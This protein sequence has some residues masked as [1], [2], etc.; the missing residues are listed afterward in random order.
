MMQFTITGDALWQRM[1]RAV[2]KVQERLERATTALEQAGIA[3]AIVGGHAV[4][5]WVAQVDEAAVRNTRDVDLLLRRVDL[6]AATDALRHAGF[7]YRHV[8]SVDLFLDGPNAKARDALHV[9]FA[10]EKIDPTYLLPAPD[11]TEAEEV[12]RHRTL[13]LD[14]L[15]RM[16]LTSFLDK[17]RMHLRDLID[18]ELLDATWLAKMPPP[19]AARLQQLLDNPD[20]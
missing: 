4:R 16:K 18:V 1:E 5:A 3:Y 8:K 2:E 20:G 17:D 12:E 11:V 19:L 9:V 6:Q 15:V 13:R 10:G 7:I 14:A